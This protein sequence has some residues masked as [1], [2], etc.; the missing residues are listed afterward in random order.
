MTVQQTSKAET[1]LLQTFSDVT[2][3]VTATHV[4]SLIID[5]TNQICI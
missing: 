5:I 2:S 4:H 1:L 3:G